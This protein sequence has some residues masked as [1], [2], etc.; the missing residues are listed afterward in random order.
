MP[1]MELHKNAEQVAHVTESLYAWRG[2]HGATGISIF[3]AKTLDTMVVH[4][5]DFRFQL[6]A[7]I[8][9]S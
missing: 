2:M 5:G 6:L 9:C 1:T 8:Q 7:H 3:F 4:D